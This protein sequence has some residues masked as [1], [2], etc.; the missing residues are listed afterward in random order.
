[1]G[2]ERQLRSQLY[3]KPLGE[4]RTTCDVPRVPLVNVRISDK[5]GDVGDLFLSIIIIYTGNPHGPS[6]LRYE[7][8]Q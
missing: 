6:R 7:A 3:D 8:S 5:P 2:I 4:H 1:M